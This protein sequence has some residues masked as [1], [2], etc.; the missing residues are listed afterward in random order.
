[1][2][3]VFPAGESTAADTVIFPFNATFA[4]ACCSTRAITVAPSISRIHMRR[5]LVF[6]DGFIWIVAVIKYFPALVIVITPDPSTTHAPDIRKNNKSMKIHTEKE[7]LL[8]CC[9][10]GKTS[11][12]SCVKIN[13]SIG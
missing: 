10:I 6:V 3:N 9:L 5:K 8:T 4:V 13:G 12:I 7:K 2:S 1:M 11:T